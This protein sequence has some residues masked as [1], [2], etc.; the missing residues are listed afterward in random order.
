MVRIKK[1]VLMNNY[2]DYCINVDKK[3]PSMHKAEDE[4]SLDRYEGYPY[5]YRK[6]TI[7]VV[8][9]GEEIKA[10]V[11]V[12]NPGRPLGEP[13]PYYYNTILEGYIDA[14]FDREVL[15][16]AVRDSAEGYGKEEA[17]C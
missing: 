1:G 12:M 10:M 15:D 16:K 6:E 14:G 13:N 2:A 8:L 9:E 17:L 3:I 11:Y 5:L 4:R 7:K